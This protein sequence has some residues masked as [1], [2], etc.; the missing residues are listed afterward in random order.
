MKIIYLLL[1][2]SALLIETLR[3]QTLKY[4]DIN[5]N[6]YYWIVKHKSD[7]IVENH[8][9]YTDSIGGAFSCFMDKI[10]DSLALNSPE[11]RQVLQ[12]Q[13]LCLAVTYNSNGDVLSIRIKLRAEEGLILTE[14]QLLMFYNVFK[15]LQMPISYN[16]KFNAIN[17]TWCFPPPWSKR[18]QY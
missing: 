12:Q 10:T 5:K 7:T 15:Y 6:D 1:L 18:Y 8:V 17:I 16:E 9:R 4:F 11:I 14:E 3:A 13:I 2:M